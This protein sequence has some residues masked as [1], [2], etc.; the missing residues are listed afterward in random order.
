MTPRTLDVSTLPSHSFGHKGLIWWGTVSFMVIEG[1]MFV[2]VLLAY[3]VLRTRVTDWP[4]SLPNPD[5]TLGTVTTVILLLSVIPN[6]MAKR[7]A[8]KYDLRHVQLVLP[9]MLLFAAGVLAIRVF[10][11]GSLNCSWDDNAYASIVWFIM[12]LHTSHV[13]T[14]AADTAVLTALM[15]TS[16]VEPRRF[17]DVSEN[18]LYWYFVVLTWIPVYLTIYFA[19]RWL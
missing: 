2:M 14:D 6:A 7:Y 1:S 11:F 16:H 17:V 15:F 4:P 10:E 12:G 9:V 13:A 5:V 3:F 18:S 19:P 8:E